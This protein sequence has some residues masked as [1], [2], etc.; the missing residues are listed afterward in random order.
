MSIDELGGDEQLTVDLFER[1]H[2]R[3]RRMG[4]GRSG[5]RL[6]PQALTLCRVAVMNGGERLQ[7][8]TPIEPQIT[9]GIDDAH[10]ATADFA[11]DLV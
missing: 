3:H 8:H 9:R 5:A 11:L 1:V 6:P 2:G 4:D 7:R 10:A